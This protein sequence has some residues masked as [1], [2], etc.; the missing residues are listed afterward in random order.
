MRVT[1]NQALISRRLRVS[2]FYFFLST[3]LMGGGFLLTFG[4]QEEL[5]Q[6]M[7]RYT[8]ATVAL[9]IGLGVWA[10]N[11]NYLTRWSPRSRQD[12]AL[13]H[14]L[15]GLDD[16]YHFFAFPDAKL[17][18]YLVVGP[19][20]VVALIPRATGGSVSCDGDRW[21]RVERIPLLL[22]ALTWFSRTAPLG[23]PT[24]DARR[25]VEQT[26]HF[27]AG[28]LPGELAERVPVEPIVVFT[29]PNLELT[30]RGCTVP[31]LRAKSLRS[32]LRSLPKSLRPEDTRQLTA[33]LGASV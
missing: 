6:D 10:V 26:K 15:R 32:H 22:R 21:R 18:D 1:T 19:M 3:A 11:Q 31:V 13:A 7:T 23:N 16:R 17:P 2:F 20:G 4:H 28:K 25:A 27:L 14:T 30:A 8:V 33:A 5:V 29:S 9:L 24:R 12:A